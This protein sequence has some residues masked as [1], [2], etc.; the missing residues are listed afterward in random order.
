MRTY[1]SFFTHGIIILT[2]FAYVNK[3]SAP[4]I[5]TLFHYWGSWLQ[6]RRVRVEICRHQ[7]NSL[8]PL[9]PMPAYSLYQIIRYSA[10]TM[11]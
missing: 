1:R 7:V 5:L 9:K 3:H 11:H 8:F 6:S 4:L 2:P 10:F